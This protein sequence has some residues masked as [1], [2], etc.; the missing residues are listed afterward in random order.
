MADTA[1]EPRG[2]SVAFDAFTRHKASPS[3]SATE[4]MRDALAAALSAV[5]ALLRAEVADEM[6]VICA[7]TVLE[8]TAVANARV[9][10]LEAL[11]DDILPTFKPGMTPNAC[12]SLVPAAKFA[13]WRAVRHAGGGE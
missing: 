9:A 13:G 6:T 3:R 7:E 12:R 10:E 4:N 2:L 1:P 5:G 8:A 11:L